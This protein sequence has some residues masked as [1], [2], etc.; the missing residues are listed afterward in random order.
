M[1]QP[2][3]RH[4]AGDGVMV[5]SMYLPSVTEMFLAQL[6]MYLTTGRGAPMQVAPEGTPLRMLRDDHLKP[7]GG[8]SANGGVHGF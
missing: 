8:C 5:G 4:A 3:T 6:P 1:I 2:K 7:A